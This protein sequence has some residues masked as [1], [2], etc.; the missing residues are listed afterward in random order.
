MGAPK[1]WV[2]ALLNLKR[3]NKSPSPEKVEN[4]S[5]S[6]DTIWDQRTHSAEIDSVILENELNQ[7]VAT[8]IEGAEDANFQS[9]SDSASSPSTSLQVQNAAEDAN[10]QSVSDSASSPS[11]L[12]QVQ[13]AAEDANFQSVSDS[14]SSPSTSLQ[15]QNAAEDANFQSVSDS[16]SSPSTQ[17]QVQNAAEDANFQSVSDSVSSPSTQL[18]VP[19]AAED[20]NFH[21]VSDSASSPS[22]S[23]QVQNA[24]QFEQNMGEEWAAIHI[25]TAFRGFLARRA[26]HALRGLVRLQALVR[27]HAVRKQSAIALHCMQAL[28]RVQARVRA[29]RVRMTLENQTAEQKLRQQLEHEARV[30]DIEEGWCG[31]GRSAQE[32]QVK[33]LKRKEAAAKREKAKAYALA[34]QWQAGSRQQVIPAGLQPDKS[35]WGWNWLER[36]MAVRPWEN[37]LLDIDLLDEIGAGEAESADVQ[38][39]PATQSISTGKRSMS[40]TRNG[41]MVPRSSN[42]SNISNGKRA[43]SRSEGCSSAPSK[44]PNVQATPTTLVS[45][46]SSRPVSRNLVGEAASTTKL[47]PRS[48]STP[49]QRSALEDKPGNKRLSLPDSGVR[50]GA[51]PVKLLNRP[52]VKRIPIAPKSMKAKTK[53]NAND[54]KPPKLTPQVAR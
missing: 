53:L 10:F 47:G 32:I 45:N 35:N 46:R 27:G 38:D 37:C 29:N 13:N 19:N 20:A 7:N 52:A 9:V 30:K 1:K 41:K 22:T 28:V 26:L 6:T 4:G 14:A 33:L 40:N 36:W 44:S 43:A 25:Q 49:K 2:K 34:R 54:I 16:V 3:S 8:E 15:V 48:R 11:P 31:G 24:T 21:S 17:L 39:V 5:G 50:H 18:Q 51:E 12:L 42:N 23:L